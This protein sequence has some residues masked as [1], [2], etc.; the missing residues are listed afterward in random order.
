MVTRMFGRGW[1]LVVAGNV[2]KSM[3]RTEVQV[4]A[5]SHAFEAPSDRIIDKLSPDP[6]TMLLSF[7]VNEL[8]HAL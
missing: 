1:M 8:T 6:V 3:S 5:T 2:I 4:G 7:P